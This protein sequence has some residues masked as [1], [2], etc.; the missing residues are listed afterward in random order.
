MF[1]LAVISAIV[2]HDRV[3]HQISGPA[4]TATLPR[5]LMRRAAVR[6]LRTIADHLEPAPRVRRVLL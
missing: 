6:A 1:D 4:A 5:G 2:A 3:A